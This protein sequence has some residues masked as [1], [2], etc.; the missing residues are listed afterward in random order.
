MGRDIIFCIELDNKSDIEFVK[1]YLSIFFKVNYPNIH[2]TFHQCYMKESYDEDDSVNFDIDLLQRGLECISKIYSKCKVC[3]TWI[4]YVGVGD[5]Y[6]NGN[7]MKDITMILM[8]KNPKKRECT[9]SVH[10]NKMK[11]GK[12]YTKD[13][14]INNIKIL[15]DSLN[16]LLSLDDSNCRII[17]YKNYK[18]KNV[19]K[20]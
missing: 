9:Y 5:I 12:N 8:D 17:K 2:Q 6:N 10:K 20:N 4:F 13:E 18:L 15:S 14:K 1:N 7:I 19:I 3:E 16:Y 11:I